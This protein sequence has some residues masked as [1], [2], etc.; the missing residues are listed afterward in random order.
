[1]ALPRISGN[2]M[3]RAVG[4]KGVLEPLNIFQTDS[5]AA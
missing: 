1:M 4:F 2:P 3:I 5:R